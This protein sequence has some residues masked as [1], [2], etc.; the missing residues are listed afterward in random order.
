MKKILLFILPL[1]AFLFLECS[2]NNKIIARFDGGFVTIQEAIDEYTIL[3]EETKAT[4]KTKN[5]YFKHVRKIAL[6]KI[7]IK[8]A[9]EQEIDKDEDF[10][11][12]LEEKKKDIAFDIL[13]KRNVY[14]KIKITEADYSKYKNLYT[15]Y[16]I[17]KRVDIL[18]KKKIEE[19]KKV[20][21]YFSKQIK[22]LNSFMETAKKYSDDVTARNGGFVGEVWLEYM[23]DEISKVMETLGEKKVSNPIETDSGL[24]LIYIDRIRKASLDELL[25]DKELYNN[26]YKQKEEKY[27]NEWY[28]SLLQDPNLK[29]YKEKLKEKIYDEEIVI[30]YYDKKITRKELFQLVDKHKE[31]GGFPEPDYN[32]LVQLVKNLSLGFIIDHK[33]AESNLVNSKEFKERFEKE[34]R[35]LLIKRF[36]DKNIVIPEISY[37][38]IKEFYEKNKKELFTF[39]LENGKFYIQPLKEVENFI[40]QKLE[41]QAIQQ[42]KYDLYRK[43]VD[44]YHLIIDDK[45]LEVLMKK[46]ANK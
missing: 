1:L 13:K 37:Q 44:K 31:S 32:E 22:D 29:I 27:E 26:I 4:I 15:L 2:F 14:E 36:I 25:K 6:E 38:E 35:F 28:N 42:A 24:Y 10:I 12:S 16:Q 33:I 17:V 5:D 18:D 7:I 20:L 19:S 41:N 39:Q 43:E 21:I 40:R 23:E 34:K 11:K 8:E 9:I 46:V 3:S 30:Q 45:L